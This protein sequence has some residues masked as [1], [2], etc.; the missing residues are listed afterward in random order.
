MAGQETAAR[1][2]EGGE[3]TP[4]PAEAFVET[5]ERWVQADRSPK[6]GVDRRRLSAG[7]GSYVAIDGI[8]FDKW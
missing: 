1:G 7:A 4:S 6:D 2:H 8:P 3:S 5:L